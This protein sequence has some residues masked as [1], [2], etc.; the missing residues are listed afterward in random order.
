MREGKPTMPASDSS[1]PSPTEV[2]ATRYALLRRLAHPIRHEM[3][4]HLQ[5]IGMVGEVLGR[6]LRQPAPDA[7][8]L[9]SGV[10]RL[11]AL[12]RA[13]VQACLDVVTWLSPEPGRVVTLQALVADTVTLLN[14]QLG[15]RGFG[16]RNEVVEAPW[17]VARNGLRMVLPACL[18]L[19]SDDAGAPA[20]IRIEA[21]REDGR[22]QLMLHLEP[23]EGPEPVLIEPSCQPLRSAQVAALARAEGIDFEHTGDTILLSAPIAPHIA[24]PTEAP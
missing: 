2:D 21:Q 15:F 11:L 4:A 6:R 24:Q 10:E 7:A 20:E 3:A 22:V 17:P 12:S 18:L 16:L 19:L 14:G 8:Q 23:G 5:P 13:A 1:A 9:Q